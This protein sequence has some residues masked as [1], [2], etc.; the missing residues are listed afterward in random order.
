MNIKYLKNT[1]PLFRFGAIAVTIY[2]T[3][4]FSERV[5]QLKTSQK[6]ALVKH[7][8]TH[9]HQQ[10]QAGKIWFVKYL[11]SKSFRLAQELVAYQ[12]EY[13]YLKYLTPSVDELK[14]RIALSLSSRT[15]FKMISYSDAMAIV[16]KW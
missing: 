14:C 3:I 7:E 2:P 9:A 12:M 10:K 6:N 16:E 5:N 1:H 13:E 8:L 4:Y 11:L 15:Y